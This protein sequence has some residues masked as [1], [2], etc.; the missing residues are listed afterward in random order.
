MG[1]IDR[2]NGEL[3]TSKFTVVMALVL[4]GIFAAFCIWQAPGWLRGP[5]TPAEVERHLG[6]I[7][8]HL[9][10]PADMKNEVVARLRTW[11]L[12]DDGRPVYMLN[13]MRYYPQ[14]R[15]FEGA[16]AFAGTPL[17]ANEYYE[18]QVMPLVLSGGIYPLFAGTAQGANLI[19]HAAE[20]DN[21]S[22]VLIV[23]YPSRR[24]VLE[25][26]SS[27]AYAPFEPYKIMALRVVLTPLDGEI[28]AA[29]LR[30]VLG[31]ALLIVFLA[32]GWLRAARRAALARQP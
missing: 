8:Q 3:R 20:L 4:S 32:V 5:L 28:V 22:R 6:Q 23:R 11:A 7:E 9:A 30:W 26:F 17:Q 25:L 10:M 13:L 15:Q 31:A 27:P 29:D 24:A 19:E 1:I 16:P 14:L 2:G 12:A 18:Q 21:W